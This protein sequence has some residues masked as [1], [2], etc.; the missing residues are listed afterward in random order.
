[1]SQSIYISVHRLW[2]PS[3]RWETGSSRVFLLRRPLASQLATRAPQVCPWSLQTIQETP[4]W[5]W[6]TSGVC[7]C[8]GGG[9]TNIGHYSHQWVPYFF[10]WK[11]IDNYV[12]II[13]A[14]L[15]T[16][17]S[18]GE[19]VASASISTWGAWGYTQA[20]AYWRVYHS[21]QCGFDLYTYHVMRSF[22][23]INVF[24]VYVF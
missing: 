24:Y 23:A 6:L 13:I 21:Y 9:A 22:R 3:R 18:G 1:M 5:Q 4:A 15:C 2:P 17:L 14:G 12:D 11:S 8:G 7:V 16:Y 10:T 19:S 20:A